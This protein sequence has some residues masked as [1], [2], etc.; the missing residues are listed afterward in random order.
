MFVCDERIAEIA[1]DHKNTNLVSK[2]GKN[3]WHCE[4]QHYTP[5]F[6]RNTEKR[7][8]YVTKT[9]AQQQHSSSIAAAQQQ[10]SSSTAEAAAAAVVAVAASKAA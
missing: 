2:K 3:G 7:Y 9:A 6:F 8:P 1:S 10:H 4:A 5:Y